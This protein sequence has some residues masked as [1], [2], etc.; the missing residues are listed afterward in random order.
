[1]TFVGVVTTLNERQTIYSLVQNLSLVVD[2]VVVVDGGSTDDTPRVASRAGALVMQQSEQKPIAHC[3]LQGWRR[4]LLMGADIIIQLDAG[5]S[6]DPASSRRLTWSILEV[7]ADIVVGS[8]FLPESKYVDGSRGRRAGSRLAARLCSAATS[9]RLSDWTS[10][11]GG[12]NRRAIELLL[13]QKYTASMHGWQIEVLGRA[14][15]LGLR[16]KE[17]P[18]TYTAGRSSFNT[19]IAREAYRVWSNLHGVR[20]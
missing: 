15:D 16:V 10:G 3:L 7:K 8:R 5:G 17:E 1:M 13:E 12:F 14:L 9:T 11:Y 6:H 20:R 2:Y 19:S 4:A 18:I